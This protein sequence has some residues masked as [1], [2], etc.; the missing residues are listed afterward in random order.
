[1]ANPLDRVRV[2]EYIEK[3]TE[4]AQTR[5]ARMAEEVNTQSF[6]AAMKVGYRLACQDNSLPVPTFMED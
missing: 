5:M 4:E 2:V 6:L 1:M 3:L